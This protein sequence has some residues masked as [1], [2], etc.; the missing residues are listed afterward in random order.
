[1]S[2]FTY[3]VDHYQG[4]L[5]FLSNIFGIAG[6]V[7]GVWRY[8]RERQV[9]AEL[10]DRQAELNETLA[11]LNHLKHLAAGVNKYSAAV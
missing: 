9:Q 2:Y 11:R 4:A 7:F 10:K 8:L 6:F 5:G 1:M 3:L